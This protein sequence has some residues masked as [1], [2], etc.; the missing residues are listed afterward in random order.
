M[1][2]PQPHASSLKHRNSLIYR[3]IIACAFILITVFALDY[4]IEWHRRRLI[5]E[6]IA[7]VQQLRVNITTETEIQEL[8]RK[9][10]GTYYG[11]AKQG[12]L[13]E[14]AHYLIA[15]W[16][17]L[18]IIRQN[19]HTLPG[20]RVW[21]AQ[22]YLPV[23]N[24]RLSEVVHF[25]LGFFRSDRLELTASVQLAGKKP[26]AAPDGVSFYVFEAHVTGPPTESLNV[27]LSPAATPEERRRGFDF[28]LSCFTG[29]RE[30]R[31]VCEVMPTAWQNLPL[32][33]RIQY[34]DGREKVTDSECRERMH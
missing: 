9:Y 7:D 11:A 22:A 30:C 26:L 4:S 28:D 2:S 5:R 32:E 34:G 16:S 17:P 19:Y 14:S 31:H 33:R 13:G 15:I 12:D 6:L 25:G 18:L 29:F 23:E 24:G 21:G 20:R 3:V 10:G 8:S 1:D 27:E